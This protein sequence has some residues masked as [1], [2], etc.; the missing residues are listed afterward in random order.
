MNHDIKYGL[1]R[2]LCYP[3]PITQPQTTEQDS[4]RC[5]ANK[6]KEKPK[7]TN[8]HGAKQMFGFGWRWCSFRFSLHF[9]SSQTPSNS[10]VS[11]FFLNL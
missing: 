11:H 6:I 10:K 7:Q 1:T 8:K 5:Q 9:L 2:L 3:K 4:L